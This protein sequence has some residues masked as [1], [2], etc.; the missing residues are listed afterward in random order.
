MF[1]ERL[2]G[3]KV[4]E[5]G[6]DMNHEACIGDSYYYKFLKLQC[7]YTIKPLFRPPRSQRIPVRGAVVARKGR[8]GIAAVW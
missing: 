5:E 4:V 6:K 1:G 8:V 2:W 3:F 7:A